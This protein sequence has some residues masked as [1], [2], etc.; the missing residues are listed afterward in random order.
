MDR[1]EDEDR[2]KRK[3][4]DRQREED[5]A[6]GPSLPQ[7][8]FFPYQFL[9]ELLCENQ[10]QLHPRFEE[11]TPRKEGEEYFANEKRGGKKKQQAMRCKER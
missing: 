1:C 8:I 7:N 5:D 6:K 2:Y 4:M 9:Q 10:I 11:P 3:N